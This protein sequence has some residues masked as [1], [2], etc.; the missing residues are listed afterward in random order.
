ME[1]IDTAKNSRD[2]REERRRKMLECIASEGQ[3]TVRD[4]VN[5]FGVS[6]VTARG[7][8]DA[9]CKLGLVDRSHGGAVRC[10]DPRQDYSIQIKAGV[11]RDEK[12]RIG[13]A[14]AELVREN[15][16][17]ILDSGTTTAEVARSIRA[18][19]RPSVTVITNALNIADE[20]VS[21]PN[22]SV[23]M[24]GGVL[25]AP[26]RSFVGPHAEH[27]L[28]TLHADH[29]FLGADGID[30]EAGPSTPNVLATHLNNVMIRSAESVTLVADASK[31]G[32]RSVYVIC[33]FAR[34]QRVI[35]DSRVDAATVSTLRERHIEV[36]IV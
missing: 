15:Q 3:L 34:I 18:L 12:A 11:H 21:A 35:T 33:S 5:R 29:F 16:T 10:F 32:H 9:L 4:I 36:L 8:L 17:V 20:L 25:L 23:L 14:A 28:S 26:S 6:P 13:R 27:M 30:V 31:F 7:D 2:L 22:A 1:A 19:D 24:V